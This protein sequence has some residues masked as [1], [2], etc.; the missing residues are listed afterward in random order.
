MDSLYITRIQ[1]AQK[2]FF[3]LKYFLDN[4]SAKNSS[5]NIQQIFEYF[6]DM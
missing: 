2:V 1:V 5:K 3:L 4:K 6:Q